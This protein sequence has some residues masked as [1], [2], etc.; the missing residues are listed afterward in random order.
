VN[1]IILEN[2][3]MAI[4]PVEC[5]L[6]RFLVEKNLLLICALIK[7]RINLNLIKNIMG[8]NLYQIY[9]SK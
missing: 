9:L 6:T 8:Y 2:D 3:L 5:S 7:H 4:D 1:G